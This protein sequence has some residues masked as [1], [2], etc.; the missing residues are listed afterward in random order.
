[1]INDVT[2]DPAL[3]RPTVAWRFQDI[4]L[5]IIFFGIEQGKKPIARMGGFVVVQVTE[6]EEDR[7]AGELRGKIRFSHSEALEGFQKGS[8]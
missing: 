8:T 2:H 4:G 1:M 3:S 7:A 6:F 5:R